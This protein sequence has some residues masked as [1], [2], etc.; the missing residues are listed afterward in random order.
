MYGNQSMYKYGGMNGI[1][2]GMPSYMNG[3]PNMN[4][5]PSYMNG[6]STMNGNGINNMEP[7]MVSQI[8]PYNMFSPPPQPTDLYKSNNLNQTIQSSQV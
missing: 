6:M 4:G 8:N 3:L 2:N 1:P 7:N 5:M